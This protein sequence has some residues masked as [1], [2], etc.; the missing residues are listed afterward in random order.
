MKNINYQISVGYWNHICKHSQAHTDTTCTPAYYMRNINYQ[1]TAGCWSHAC[2]HAH[3]MYTGLIYE[4]HKLPKYGSRTTLESTYMTCT[5]ACSMKNISKYSSGTTTACMHTQT[6]RSHWY[7]SAATCT[8]HKST[9][10]ITCQLHEKADHYTI[11]KPYLQVHT[12]TRHTNNKR[13]IIWKCV[14]RK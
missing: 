3:D 8:R 4:E 10:Y 6:H 14:K 12:S 2:K 9:L 7:G 1:N 13:I 5:P 11:L